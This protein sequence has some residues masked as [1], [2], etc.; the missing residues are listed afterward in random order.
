MVRQNELVL[1]N[2]NSGLAYI[3]KE[4]MVQWENI[5]V[6][7]KKVFS[8]E[9][10]KKG[11]L[12][13]KSTYNRTSPCENCVMQ[14]AFVSLQTE[15]MK[16]SLDSAHTVEVFATPVVLEDG[17]VDGVVIRVD[18]VTEREKMIKELQEAKHQAEQS[19]KLKSAFL[20][21]MSHEIRT[22]LNAIVGF[23]ELMLMPE[24]KKRRTIS[25]LLIV[26]MSYC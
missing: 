19:D 3:T 26:I 12:C 24:K 9:A 7:F 14:R 13:Y 25:R 21:N 10:Y 18:D 22:P 17:S 16:F 20:A 5:F 15:Q 1:N 11:E 8:F 4:Y 2:T 23:S 6:M